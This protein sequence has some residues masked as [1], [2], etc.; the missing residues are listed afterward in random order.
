MVMPKTIAGWFTV[1]FFVVFALDA[2]R[3]YENETVF[4]LLA[5]GVALFTLI[6]KQGDLPKYTTP[7]VWG[8][9]YLNSLKENLQAFCQG[10]N[11]SYLR[12]QKYRA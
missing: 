10:S 6:G 11:L 3:M 5:A 9:I 2:F 7:R 8:C 4:G 12:P 1:L